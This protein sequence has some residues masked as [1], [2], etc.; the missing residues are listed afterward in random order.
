[1]LPE[2]EISS[3]S[4]QISP[5]ITHLLAN[6]PRD[7]VA[8]LPGLK[9]LGHSSRIVAL[10]FKIRHADLSRQGDILNGAVL[11][12]E[13]LALADDLGLRLLRLLRL[14]LLLLLRVAI[15]GLLLVALRSIVVGGVCGSGLEVGA[16]VVEGVVVV[17]LGLGR[18]PGVGLGGGVGLRLGV[19][20]ARGGGQDEDEG[21][22]G[23]EDLEEGLKGGSRSRGCRIRNSVIVLRIHQRYGRF[24]FR[25]I[26]VVSGNISLNTVINSSSISRTEVGNSVVGWDSDSCRTLMHIRA[27]QARLEITSKPI[28]L[29]RETK[30]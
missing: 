21:G 20:E 29:W 11:L 25:L 15:G 8:V 30:R 16:A 22:V 4:F 5:L 10:G 9:S 12:G 26:L 24:P 28:S 2:N 27:N 18:R 19:G 13:V 7:V 14:L 6:S 1:M 23:R 3:P 17:V